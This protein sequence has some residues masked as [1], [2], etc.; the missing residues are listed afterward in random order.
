[1][2]RF[3]LPATCIFLFGV[4]LGTT[5]VDS[6]FVDGD[7]SNL[8]KVEEAYSVI[9][10]RY[11]DGVDADALTQSAIYG[12]LDNL[13]PHST[14]IS[15]SEVQSVQAGFEGEFGGVGIWYEVVADSPRVSS[16][17]P[18]GPS[19]RAGIL[20]GDRIVA[21]E[22]FSAVGDSTRTVQR[23]LRGKIGTDVSVAVKRRGVD[24]LLPFTIVRGSIPLFS[25][26]AAYMLDDR[27]G[28]IRMGR[29]AATTHGEFMEK[30]DELQAAGMERIVVDVRDNPGGVMEAAVRIADEFLPAGYDIVETKGRRGSTTR[31]ERSTDGGR[32]ETTPVIVLVNENSA[33]ASEILAGAI[34]DNDRGLVVGHRTFGKALVQQQFQL[35]DGSVIHLTVSRYYTPS[36]RLIQTPYEGAD[37]SGYLA[38]KFENAYVL[39]A[40]RL[41]DSLTFS[42]RT[43]RVVAGG[44]GILP[45]HIVDAEASSPYAHPLLGAVTR[46][47]ADIRF[48]RDLFDREQD[49]WRV[50]WDGREAEFMQSYEVDDALLASFWRFVDD[51]R[52]LSGQSATGDSA[53]RT[54]VGPPLRILLKAR[55]A[56]NLFG[57]AAYYPVIQAV[58]VD[59]D[60]VAESWPEAVAFAEPYAR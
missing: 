59:L 15:R 27:T 56:Q 51:G 45:D 50:R 37:M 28:L 55:I 32:L 17:V 21:I 31:V 6:F 3:I 53:A 48:V 43:G 1:M 58:D 25:V 39:D 8:R 49:A 19:A 7:A 14:Y 60:V 10:N 24:E 34:Q 52:I 29:F 5:L 4:L 38:Q 13:D 30:V 35:D 40:E 46:T 22:G 42:T 41:P 2:R 20:P 16:V 9:V 57:I 26:D 47:M 23:R 11:V 54:A 18:E 33:S 44:G 36:G 12:M